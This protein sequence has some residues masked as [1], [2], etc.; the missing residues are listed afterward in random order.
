MII[1]EAL[2]LAVA[3]LEEMLVVLVVDSESE[4]ES[5]PGSDSA[6]SGDSDA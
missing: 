3:Q 5:E 6:E 2:P 1:I 4:S